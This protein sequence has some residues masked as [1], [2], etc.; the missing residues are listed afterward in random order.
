MDLISDSQATQL[1]APIMDNDSI[2]FPDA[3]MSTLD[4]TFT[5]YVYACALTIFPSSLTHAAYARFSADELDAMPMRIQGSKV[6]SGALTGTPAE[7]MEFDS[8]WVKE[9]LVSEEEALEGPDTFMGRPVVYVTTSALGTRTLSYGMV[10]DSVWIP[11][12]H[13]SRFHILSRSKEPDVVL[14]ST[15]TMREVSL[16]NYCF[17][18]LMGKNSFAY[19]W[20]LV[21]ATHA[22]INQAW[23]T[24]P[25]NAKW[26]TKGVQDKFLGTVSL[27]LPPGHRELAICDMENNVGNVVWCPTGQILDFDFYTLHDRIPPKKLTVM[28]SLLEPLHLQEDAPTEEPLAKKTKTNVKSPKSPKTKSPRRKSART[29]KFMDWSDAADNTQDADSSADE[30]ADDHD[31]LDTFLSTVHTQAPAPTGPLSE[32]VRSMDPRFHKQAPGPIPASLPP[33]PVFLPTEAVDNQDFQSTNQRPG[34]PN[35]A[36]NQC[37]SANP[38]NQ[39]PAM[40]QFAN[41]LGQAAN[42]MK[43]SVDY[44]ANAAQDARR[45]KDIR[46]VKMTATQ[47]NVFNK[48]SN[49]MCAS[50]GAYTSPQVLFDHMQT[51]W[52][53]MGVCFHPLL[54]KGF[55]SF[56]FGRGCSITEFVPEDWVKVQARAENFDGMDDFSAKAKR[57]AMPSHLDVNNF[58]DLL[59]CVDTVLKLCKL[60]FQPFMTEVVQHLR[61][62]LSDQSRRHLKPAKPFMVNVLRW[63]NNRLFALRY[64]ASIGDPNAVQAVISSFHTKAEEWSDIMEVGQQQEAADLRAELASLKA[65]MGKK[66][67]TNAPKNPKKEQRGARQPFNADKKDKKA[68]ADR[69]AFSVLTGGCP[70]VKGKR[71]C[72]PNLSAAGCPNT[73]EQCNL[74]QFCHILPKKES[75]DEPWR[76]V[77]AQYYGPLKTELA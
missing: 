58:T 66:T 35:V 59:A 45:D 74:K 16:V 30:D 37:D 54:C 15:A 64:A 11:H 7:T 42:H 12:M 23:Q 25:T 46:T 47:M 73:E 21:E 77:F 61:D 40:T 1:E 4:S 67:P 22:A 65:S 3:S 51:A 69:P 29:V 5:R 60:L 18:P 62:F 56:D 24:I 8:S 19:R 43:Q 36:V 55:F 2:T 31:G 26:S 9:N 6:L 20:P 63:V 14:A 44:V 72:F 53:R 13:Q 27:T 34:F 41:I 17:Q 50:G 57:P 76:L 71:V 28:S 48:I 75:L 70:P 10:I 33:V 52:W 38:T 39:H 49:G 68:S 32:G